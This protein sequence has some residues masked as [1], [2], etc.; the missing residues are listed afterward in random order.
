MILLFAQLPSS[1]YMSTTLHMHV[2]L[3][4]AMM[5][6]LKT[7][8]QLPVGYSLGFTPRMPPSRPSSRSGLRD[9]G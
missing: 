4:T 3:L 6:I 2:L 5:H 8:T 1:Q 7:L 9:E